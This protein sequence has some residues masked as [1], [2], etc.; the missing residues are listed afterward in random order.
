MLLD[1]KTSV[2]MFGSGARTGRSRRIRAPGFFGEVLGTYNPEHGL[3]S[4]FR[5][6]NEPTRRD[7]HFGFRVVLV[8]G[9]MSKPVTSS[10]AS[11]DKPFEN[12]IGMKFVP[13]PI[14]GGPSD[15]KIVLASVWE[16]RVKN[17]AAFSEAA[18]RDWPVAQFPQGNDHP[19]V[20]VNWEDASAFCR[21]LTAEERWSGNIGPNDTYRLPSDHEWSCAV[22]IGKDENAADT[23]GAK[24]GKIAG[25]PWGQSFPPPKGAGNFYGEE[26]KRNPLPDWKTIPGYDDEFDRTAPVGRFTPNASGLFDLSGNVWEWC[27]DRVDPAFDESVLRGGSWFNSV[28][29]G[30][31]SSCR[32]QLLSERR[33]EFGFRAVLEIGSGSPSERRSPSKTALA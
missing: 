28:S 8:P 33:S 6:P 25:Y 24:D 26:T 1:S 21:W 30:L 4:S 14:T 20:S 18:T 5:G 32:F 2:A 3:Q 13:V 11:K 12:H 15:G 7:V 22:G 27:Q 10:T 23:P 9:R 17:Y 31:R 29:S 19:A 16:T